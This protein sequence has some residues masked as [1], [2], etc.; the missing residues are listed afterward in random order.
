MVWFFYMHYDVFNNLIIQHLSSTEKDPLMVLLS[1]RMTAD[2]LN[3]FKGVF[4]PLDESSS[5]SFSFSQAAFWIFFP[6]LA[7]IQSQIKMPAGR[8]VHT[9]MCPKLT[10]T[11][12]RAAI[13]KK[14]LV[15]CKDAKTQI[16]NLSHPK[17]CRS[18]KAQLPWT[19]R[20]GVGFFCLRLAYSYR[21]CPYCWDCV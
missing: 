19:L 4:L 11:W 9:V 13:A 16:L 18:K 17:W 6:T 15:A 2:L 7:G 14:S 12:L 3:V 20:S 1:F 5:S 8:L 21:N 10:W